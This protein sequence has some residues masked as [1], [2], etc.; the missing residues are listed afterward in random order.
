MKPVPWNSKWNSRF[1][2]S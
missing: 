2:R 1:G